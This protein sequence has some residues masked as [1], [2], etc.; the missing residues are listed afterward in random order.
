MYWWIRRHISAVAFATGFVWD[1]LTLTRIDLLY[2][3]IVFIS[4]LIIAFVGILLV[5]G[6]E[7]RRFAPRQL[8]RV[9]VWLPAVVQFPLG[10]L[11][12]GFVIFYTKSASLFTS[13]PFLIILFSLFVGNEFFRKRYEKLVFQISLFYF[14]LFSYLV[15]VTP[16][17]LKAMGTSTFIFAGVLSLFVMWFL[18]QLV[19][20]LF[21]RLFA[22]GARLI[23]TIVGGI[24]IGFNVLYFTNTI[25]PVPLALKEM[26]VYHDVVRSGTGYR[27]SYEKPA[28]YESWR[29][30]SGV[31]HRTTG[32][33]AYCFSSVFAPTHLS[34]EIS[35]SWQRKMNN[36]SWMRE[37]L[38]PFTVE[39]GR[40]GGY[41]GYTFK[42][43]LSEGKWRCVV[44]TKNGQVIGQM[45]FNVV[46][47][48]EITPR[49]EE[50]R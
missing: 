38:I 50:M 30:T 44:E 37:E 46:D 12:S 10:G 13:W 25:P 1:T 28:W 33:A 40:D 14:A 47:V 31:F 2:E 45:S 21:P 42:Q 35:H 6:V 17:V 32:G 4:Y 20:K 27:V 23:F 16:I 41:R 39:G 7:T 11:F 26:G 22:Q 19:R 43:N 9:R 15:L 3:N 48:D 5:H 34:V 29:D 24:Y 49:V 36:G 18:L 8:L